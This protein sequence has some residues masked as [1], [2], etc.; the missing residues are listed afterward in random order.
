M[1]VSW[2]PRAARSYG[3]ST[4]VLLT[5]VSAI[6]EKTVRIQTQAT[7][8]LRVLMDMKEIVKMAASTLT[9]VQLPRVRM[10]GHATTS[11]ILTPAI[12]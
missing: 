5:M 8:V 4:S 9:N 11:R 1:H 6:Q 12:V 7:N 2:A 10:M 3:A